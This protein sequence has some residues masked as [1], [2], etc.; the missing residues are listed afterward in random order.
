MRIKDIINESV[1]IDL[2]TDFLKSIHPKELRYY[3]IRDNCGPA[4]LHMKDW[5]KSKGIELQRY[6]G[7]FT[8]DDVAYDKADFTKEMKREFLRQGLDFNDPNAR[9]QFIKS[10]PEYSEEWKKIPHYW[11]QDKLGSVYDPTGYIQF[12]KTGL[13]KDLNSSRYNGKPS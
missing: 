1:S 7:Y 13:A 5:A 3:S 8:A 2:V 10:N 6:G 12:I 4:A 11:L 9:K